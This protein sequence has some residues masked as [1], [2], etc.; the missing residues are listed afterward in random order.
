MQAMVVEVEEEE[1]DLGKGTHKQLRLYSNMPPQ[2][3]QRLT[4]TVRFLA[5]MSCES[6]ISQLLP[7]RLYRHICAAQQPTTC[8]V[9]V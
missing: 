8:N 5:T 4:D 9:Q 6:I 1:R 2:H 3:H 7:R